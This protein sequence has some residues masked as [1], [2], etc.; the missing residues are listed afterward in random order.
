MSLPGKI[1]RGIS[2]CVAARLFIALFLTFIYST[3]VCGVDVRA[4]KQVM[5][6]A[7]PASAD[8]P[9]AAQPDTIVPMRAPDSAARRLSSDSS[10]AGEDSTMNVAD[11]AAT[12]ALEEQ[13]GIR[14][15]RDA[16]SSKVMDMTTNVFFLY[17]NAKVEY[18][19]LTLDAGRVTYEQAT[20]IVTAEP[21]TDTSL[22][23]GERP[24]FTQGQEKFTYDWLRYN[25]NSK[26]AIVRNARTQH[27][28]GFVISEQVKRSPDQ[29]IY[30]LHSTY[31]TCNLDTPHFG[32]RARR[33][34]V[35]PGRIAVSGAANIEIEGVPTPAYLPFAF[36]PVTTT[37]KSG[38]KLPSYTFEQQRGL[39]LTNGGYYFHFSE[40]ADLLLTGNIYT[41]GSFTAS[42]VSTYVKRYKFNGG[43]NFSY[44][45]NKYGE[46][47]EPGSRIEK[48]FGIT[49][50]HQTDPKARPGVSFNSDVNIVKNN[51]YQQFSY[52]PNQIIQNTFVSNITFMRT[53]TTRPMNFTAGLRHDQNT[54]TRLVNVSLPDVSFNYSQIT[55]FKR[56]NPIGA[57][58]WYERIT[59]SYTF[60]AVN[61]TS[62]YDSTFQIGNLDA[63]RFRNGFK[64]VIPI[65]ASYPLARFF[66][67][68]VSANYNEY[69]I[70][71]RQNLTYNNETLRAD[72]T[73]QRGFFTA[74]DF[75]ANARVTTQIFGTKMFKRGR[76][77]G[78]RHVIR[79]TVGLGYTPDFAGA[80]FRYAQL[81]KLDS[82][83]APQ[84]ISYFS[85]SADIVGIPGGQFGDFSSNL[86]YSVDNLLQ[87]KLRGRRTDTGV[88]P[89]KN[90]SLIDGLSFS[91]GH[92]FAADSFRW[93]PV[94][95]NFRTNIANRV[96][97]SANTALDPYGI[98]Y[99]TGAR[100][101]TTA[102]ERGVGIGRIGTV[103]VSLDATLASGQRR[104]G[105]ERVAPRTDAFTRTM[106]PG[107]YAGYVDF[108]V[109]WNLSLT[110][111]L[112]VSNNYSVTRRADTLIFNQQFVSA[113]G[114][115]NLTPRWRVTASTQ[116]DLTNKQIQLSEFSIYRDLHCWAMSLSTIPFGI[117]KHYNF[118]L[119][120]KA[121]VLQDLKLQRRRDF[122][123]A[124]F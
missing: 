31:T 95:I 69:W 68:S 124:V 62:F 29:S 101:R 88:G 52:N 119:N 33:I 84:Y 100:Q 30:G 57:P 98:D 3:L 47:Y 42:A 46:V 6:K 77:V 4:Q 65:S 117:R 83:R 51:F 21:R 121:S 72:T 34:K 24:T 25:F 123:D 64:H 108:N 36:F 86:T 79:P 96:R 22:A 92:N 107:G 8:S 85:T 54:T 70:T 105:P 106:L 112:G 12:V 116:Y 23:A 67:F 91:G 35:I 2:R 89:S 18:E 41:R 99:E 17:G 109:P 10:L 97:I 40:Y 53:W 111:S 80:P 118:T 11:S 110:Y 58:K 20:G 39:G 90:V 93:S 82:A 45:Y 61:K 44:G 28:E 7:P 120:V 56:R 81:V 38:F 15:S 115:V 59:T 1:K 66:T 104:Q 19:D 122:R 16:L 94:A 103:Q 102:L 5:P 32:I 55:P 113:R 27:G 71:E 73:L 87:M 14:I 26:R 43:F 50:R 63:L 13:L 37:Q 114:E 76:V 75:N 60:N 49:W 48:A 78:L 9:V 74:R